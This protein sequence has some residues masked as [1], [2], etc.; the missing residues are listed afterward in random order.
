MGSGTLHLEILEDGR[1]VAVKKT[2]GFGGS[3]WTRY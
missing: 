3:E 1:I 2:G